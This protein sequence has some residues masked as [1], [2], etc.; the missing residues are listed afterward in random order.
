LY[1]LNGK[2]KHQDFKNKY[3]ENRERDTVMALYSHVSIETL[4]LG[5]HTSET[6]TKCFGGSL[7]FLIFGNWYIFRDE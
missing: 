2:E 7:L 6:K 4:I 3:S 1:Q 5:N